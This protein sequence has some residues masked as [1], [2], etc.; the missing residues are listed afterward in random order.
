MTLDKIPTFDEVKTWV[1]NNSV[2][3]ISGNT[4]DVQFATESGS[5]GYG[6]WS[7]TNRTINFNNAY[8]PDTFIPSVNG[9]TGGQTY[10][11]TVADIE[12]ISLNTDSNGNITGMEVSINSGGNSSDYSWYVLGVKK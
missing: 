11:S 10:E 2:L 6:E 3:S 12:I 1:S 9:S 7:S 5:F 4:G 8:D